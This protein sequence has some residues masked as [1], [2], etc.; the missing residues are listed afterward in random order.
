MDVHIIG[1]YTERFTQKINYPLLIERLAGKDI[2]QHPIRVRQGVYTDMACRDDTDAIYGVSI[3][4]LEKCTLSKTGCPADVLIWLHKRIEEKSVK[5]WT[6][7]S[8][9]RSSVVSV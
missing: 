1:Q 4:N 3:S 6:V 8:L 9:M 2:D 5:V 7:C